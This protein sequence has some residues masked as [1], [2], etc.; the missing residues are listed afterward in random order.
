MIEEIPPSKREAH[1]H[2]RSAR[3]AQEKSHICVGEMCFSNIKIQRTTRAETELTGG[4]KSALTCIKIPLC[5]RCESV[6]C[7]LRSIRL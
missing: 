2:V 7:P 4:I 6:Q 3:K 5:W 1:S